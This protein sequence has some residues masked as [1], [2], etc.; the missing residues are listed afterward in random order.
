MSHIVGND[1]ATKNETK[2]PEG[3]TPRAFQSKE[4]LGALPWGVQL[5]EES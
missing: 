5:A 4:F 1:A 2:K 3:F